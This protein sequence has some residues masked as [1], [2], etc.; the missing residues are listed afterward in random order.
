M[1]DLKYR[2][3]NFSQV[4]GNQGP[5]TVL[6]KRSVQNDL[7]NRSIL[8]GGPKGC[9]KTTLA[10]IIARAIICVNK[11]N[12]EPCNECA[13]CLSVTHEN[14][15]SVYEFDAAT[16]GTVEN[17]RNI[18][19]NLDY[20]NIDGNQT[21]LILDEAHRLSPAS[22]DAI[23]KVME[24]RRLLVIMCTTEPSKIRPAVR[25]RLEEYSI[26]P[27]ESIDIIKRLESICTKEGIAYDLESLDYIVK[28]AKNSPRQSINTLQS[29]A[30]LGAVDSQSTRSYLR[31]DIVDIVCS[32]LNILSENLSYCLR[33]LSPVIDSESP[34]W[35]RDTIVKVISLSIRSSL[36][37]PSSGPNI[38]VKSEEIPMWASL[39]KSIGSIEK[40]TA[41]DI[42]MCIISNFK[43]SPDVKFEFKNTSP[44]VKHLVTP[45]HD[46]KTSI[47]WAFE[48]KNQVKEELKPNRD[49]EISGVIFSSDEN[50]TSVDSKM[51]S[52]RG[53]TKV[54]QFSALVEFDRDRIPI[55]EQEFSRGFIEK[56]K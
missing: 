51:G 40:P 41:Y 17:I 55:S 14:S 4:L 3:M 15:V 30:F 11:Q 10:R 8:L 43:P 19:D 36:G 22:Q 5:V 37:M 1:L 35:V 53:V 52:G 38:I 6:L 50:L 2:P 26:K 21:I 56:Y 29:I 32:A 18:V 13:Q 45:F 33:E 9:G 16:H 54:E 27:S 25:D 24:D 12:G 28:N 42:E 34:S 39:A 47:S 7:R 31:L 23:L 48:K 49:I 20:E 44:T 46:S